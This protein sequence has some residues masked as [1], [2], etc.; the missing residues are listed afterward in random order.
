MA[1]H[2]SSSKIDQCGTHRRIVEYFYD[3]DIGNYHFGQG[4]PMK[5]HR[6]RMAHNLIVAYGLYRQMRVWRPL[7]NVMQRYITSFHDEEYYDFLR[8]VTPDNVEKFQKQLRRYNMQEDCPVFHGLAD[9]CRVYTSGSVGSAVRL[10]EGADVCVNWSGGMH[11]AKRSEASGF[12]YVNDI[13]IAILELLKV[14][15]RVLYIDIDIHHGDG[16]EEAFYC[17]DRVMTLS[18]HKFGDFFPG[19]GDVKDV[20]H[21]QGRN[22]ALNFPLRDGMDDNA[23]CSIFEPVVKQVMAHYQPGAV[24]MCCGAD[25]LSGDRL[26]CWNLSLAGHSKCIEFVRGFGVPLLL[27]GGGGYTMRNVARC[28][29]YETSRMLGVDLADELPFNEYQEYYGPEYK[30]H[31]PPTKDMENLNERAYL[32]GMTQQLLETLKQTEAAP[33]VA[34]QTGQP[35]TSQ[36]PRALRAPGASADADDDVPD[37]EDAEEAAADV[38]GG[39]AGRGAVR[40]QHP[41]EAYDPE[42]GGGEAE[43]EIKMRGGVLAPEALCN[44]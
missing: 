42:E 15:M 12:C 37:G 40:R 22:Y 43:G 31:L 4:H 33:G 44:E 17:T 10:N 32:A 6:V 2:S 3:Q 27:L 18:Y 36:T 14:H 39:T 8:Q 35:G 11:H 25:S 26:G 29:T 41:G 21:G 34:I 23:Y 9:Y 38:R 20:G 1:S 30:L 16:V 28:W 7:T 13:V 19:T 5:P 24:V